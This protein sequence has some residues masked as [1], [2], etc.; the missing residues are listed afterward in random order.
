MSRPLQVVLAAAVL[1]AALWFVALRP[2]PD[3]GLSSP[4]A[5]SPAASPTASAPTSKPAPLA[6]PAPVVRPAAP[7]KRAPTAVPA[8]APRRPR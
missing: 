1:F 5:A 6:K 7:V 8:I 4:P 2:K 3:S